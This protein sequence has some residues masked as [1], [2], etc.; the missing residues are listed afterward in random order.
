M[1]VENQLKKRPGKVSPNPL[2][3]LEC[4][5]S[6]VVHGAEGVLHFT[7]SFHGIRIQ[8]TL[9][10]FCAPQRSSE[11]GDVWQHVGFYRVTH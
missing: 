8:Q 7:T 9:H 1:R 4:Q 10:V 2:N 6:G 11:D 3:D 5:F